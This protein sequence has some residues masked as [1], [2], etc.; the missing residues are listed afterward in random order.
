MVKQLKKRDLAEYYYHND[1]PL[2]V[3]YNEMKLRFKDITFEWVKE[4]FD[5]L[6]ARENYDFGEPPF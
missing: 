3:A 6:E 2:D 4:I 5:D 1:Y